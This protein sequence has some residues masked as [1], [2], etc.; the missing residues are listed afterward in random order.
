MQIKY[1]TGFREVLLTSNGPARVS[2]PAARHWFSSPI[3][4]GGFFLAAATDTREGRIRAE[5]YIDAE[6]AIRY[7][8]ALERDRADIESKL[9]FPLDWQRLDGQKACRIAIRKN[10]DPRDESTWPEQHEWLASRLNRMHEVLAPRV[11]VLKPMPEKHDDGE[12]S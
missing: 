4:R 7:F 5:L 11:R 1:W 3:G 9:G 8:E 10:V 2:E 12:D 6:D